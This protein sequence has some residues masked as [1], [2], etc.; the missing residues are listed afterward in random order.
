MYNGLG[1][2]M[3]VDFAA[4]WLKP[5]DETSTIV[6]SMAEYGV[7]PFRD[8]FYNNTSV[9]VA[10]A[11]HI[12]LQ[13]VSLGFDLDRNNWR[14]IPLKH[15]RLYLYANNL[16]IIW[17]ANNFGLDPDLVPFADRF[18][19]PEPRSIAFGLKADF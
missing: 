9:T 19:T 15:I 14:A 8:G 17:K 7:D 11:D 2:S 10:R 18:L 4:R 13:D 16:G 3:N 1:S 5:G 6:P 12:R